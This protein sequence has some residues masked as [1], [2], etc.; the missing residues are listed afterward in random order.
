[1]NAHGSLEHL[2]SQERYGDPRVPSWSCF[3]CHTTKVWRFRLLPP[4]SRKLGY[5]HSL[6]VWQTTEHQ[7]NKLRFKG[8]QLFV[9][10]VGQTFMHLHTILIFCI[11]YFFKCMLWKGSV[12]IKLRQ[13]H[14]LNKSN[15]LF[16][17]S[18]WFTFKKP[19]ILW[20]ST[21]ERGLQRLNLFYAKQYIHKGVLVSLKTEGNQKR[22]TTFEKDINPLPQVKLIYL[23]LQN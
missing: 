9:V 19:V 15:L 17:F 11:F 18:R 10:V 21:W 13:F 3:S 16:P 8:F 12:Y 7:H 14:S 23:N 20:Q 2:K 1:V 6:S 4:R 22:S 5:I